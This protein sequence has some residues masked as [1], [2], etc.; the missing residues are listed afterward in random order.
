ME[1]LKPLEW[2]FPNTGI[3]ILHEK[4]GFEKFED[5]KK[6]LKILY[7]GHMEFLDSKDKK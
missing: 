7:R 1:E 3:H 5:R 6:A 2:P 4:K